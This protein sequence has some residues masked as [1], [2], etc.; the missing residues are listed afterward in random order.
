MHCLSPMTSGLRRKIEVDLITGAMLELVSEGVTHMS[1][2][3]WDSMG[4]H[5]LGQVGLA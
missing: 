4:R 5:W 1:P 2:A 3:S